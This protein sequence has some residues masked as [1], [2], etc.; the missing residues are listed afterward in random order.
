MACLHSSVLVRPKLSTLANAI[1][2]KQLSY[3][4]IVSNYD[5]LQAI[6]SFL[7]SLLRY[8]LDVISYMALAIG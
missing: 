8:V 4:R 6:E 3:G 7:Q 1:H 5:R 2:C